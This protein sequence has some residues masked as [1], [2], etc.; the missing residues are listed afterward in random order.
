MTNC[1]CDVCTICRRARI[2]VSESFGIP[3]TRRSDSSGLLIVRSFDDAYA[4]LVCDAAERFGNA[5][6]AAWE[7]ELDADDLL[8]DAQRA[9]ELAATAEGEVA[10]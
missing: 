3:I 10:R 7:L 8:L 1:P 5:E 2:A 6:L 4:D 9:D